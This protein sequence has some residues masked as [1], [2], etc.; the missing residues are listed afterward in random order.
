MLNPTAIP[1][2]PRSATTFTFVFKG[3]FNDQVK[4]IGST[5][6][7]MSETTLMTESA[8]ITGGKGRHR[9]PGLVNIVQ[10]VEIGQQRK[11]LTKSIAT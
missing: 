6:I 8:I 3:M 4:I 10:Y 9:P 7:A 2:S 1:P 11:A 5:K